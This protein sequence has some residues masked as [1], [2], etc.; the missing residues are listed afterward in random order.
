MDS[1][2][3]LFFLF[4]FCF[5]VLFLFLIPTVMRIICVLSSRLPAAATIIVNFTY[6]YYFILFIFI[7]CACYMHTHFM[8]LTSH[9]RCDTIAS[10]A[11][12]RSYYKIVFFCRMKHAKHSRGLARALFVGT[13]F[14]WT[15]RIRTRCVLR[16]EG[17][18]MHLITSRRGFR[19]F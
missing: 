15:M 12:V 11:V 4:F 17:R 1:F 9:A 19:S 3:F 18:E 6:G 10:R 7:L 8:L 16:E 2:F 14:A 13:H 5:L